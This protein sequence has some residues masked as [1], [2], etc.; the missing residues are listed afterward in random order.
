MRS[1]FGCGFALVLAQ[2]PAPPDAAPLRSLFG[3]G[4]ALVLAQ[5]PA[6]LDAAPSGLFVGCGAVLVLAQFPAPLRGRPLRLFFTLLLAQSHGCG[7]GWAGI[8]ARRLRRHQ[9]DH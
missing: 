4:F 7:R 5:F 1:L 8:S 3:C 9:Y 2:F 6:P